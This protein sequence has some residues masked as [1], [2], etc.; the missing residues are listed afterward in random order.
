MNNM[1]AKIWKTS[2]NSKYRLCNTKDDIIFHMW[3]AVNL[4]KRTIKNFTRVAAML[5]HHL[6]KKYGLP[7]A[8]NAWEHTTDKIFEND[9]TKIL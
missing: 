2:D 6:C 3:L 1:K 8:R 4:L 7:A 9:A 5:Y